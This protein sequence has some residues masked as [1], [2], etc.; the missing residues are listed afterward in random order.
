MALLVH[1]LFLV[2]SLYLVCVVYAGQRH[3]NARDTLH[4]A[5]RL[6]FKCLWNLAILVAVMQICQF[7]F[8]P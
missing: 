5:L 3:D 4:A 7:L 2:P 6:S 1:L 8:L